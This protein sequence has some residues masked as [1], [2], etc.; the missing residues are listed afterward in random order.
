M[1]NHTINELYCKSSGTNIIDLLNPYFST[2]ETG[3]IYLD[4]AKIFTNITESKLDWNPYSFLIPKKDQS[5]FW[6]HSYNGFPSI[7]YISSFNSSYPV[8]Q[9]LALITRTNLI[10]NVIDDD[11][12]LEECFNFY[13]DGRSPNYSY[14]EFK[15]FEQ[16]LMEDYEVENAN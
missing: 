7:Q 9:K 16:K 5:G 14:K 11:N 10:L 6:T 4:I 3:E 8:I 2:S 12:G 1:S 15:T 13:S